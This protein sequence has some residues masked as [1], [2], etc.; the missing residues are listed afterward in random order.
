[1]KI[2]IHE[3]VSVPDTECKKDKN[4]KPKFQVDNQ[5]RGIDS[6]TLRNL[7]KLNKTHLWC[8][9]NTKHIHWHW[10]SWLKWPPKSTQYYNIHVP[11][12]WNKTFCA[13]KLLTSSNQHLCIYSALSYHQLCPIFFPAVTFTE[14]SN[15]SRPLHWVGK[16]KK[17]GFHWTKPQRAPTPT[18]HLRW[19]AN[20]R[21]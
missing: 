7:T 20:L 9:N 1:M 5:R 21:N 6:K 10:L 8:L 3:L 4:R 13:D 19:P 18:L 15:K 11:P 16:H 14:S 2:Y 12:Y 17:S